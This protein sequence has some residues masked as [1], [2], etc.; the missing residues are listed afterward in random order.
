MCPDKKVNLVQQKARQF[1]TI[2]RK[3][4]TPCM[5]GCLHVKFQTE[6]KTEI[7]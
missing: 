5:L 4:H 2:D 3:D 7:F 1:D 6:K